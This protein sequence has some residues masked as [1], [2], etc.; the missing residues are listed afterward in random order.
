MGRQ[1]LED[2]LGKQ[3]L[4]ECSACTSRA[5][6]HIPVTQFKQELTSIEEVTEEDEEFVF[7]GKEK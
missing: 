4:V 1:Q 5:K 6:K 2:G 3:G 7:E